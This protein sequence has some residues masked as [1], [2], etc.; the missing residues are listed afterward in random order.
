MTAHARNTLWMPA[1]L[2]ALAF[3]SFPGCSDDDPAVPSDDNDDGGGYVAPDLDGTYVIVDTDQSVCYDSQDEI[4]APAVGDA[5]YGQDAQIDGA[6]P[7]YV[8]STDSLTVYDEVTGLTWVRSADTDGDGQLES[9]VDKLTWVDAQTYPAEL[10][11]AAFGGFD[12]WRLP[13]I[14]ELYSLI[15]FSGEDVSPEAPS[16]GVPFIDTDI[17]SFVYGNTSAGERII[18]SQY[19]SS[20]L[21]VA[22]SIE[23]QLLFGVNFAD[24]RIKGYGL[25]MPGMG[26]KTFFVQCVRGNTDY[27]INVFTDNGDGTVS[28]D[29]TGL[30]WAQD[31]SGVDVSAGLNWEEALAWVKTQNAAGFL[32][33]GDWRL[34]NVK[35]LQS[36]V[37]YTRSPATTGSAAIDPVFHATSIINEA[38]EADYAFYW[39]ST[40]H[41]SAMG[42]GSGAYVAFGRSLGYMDGSWG[43]VHGA[44]SQRSDPKSGDPADFPT[45]NG[46]Q[47]DAIRIYNHVRLVR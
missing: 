14:K 20:T 21:Y 33:Y 4:A 10:N 8:V 43:D 32:G 31:D 5:F 28:D 44:G 6:Q 46:P 1:L 41:A 45:G 25:V 23:G 39:S 36:I 26:D 17:F 2:L 22:D 3:G 15:R 40:T 18:D 13:T 24:G 16:G 47:G 9:P 12:D 19:A 35:E 34:P 38:G 27:G 37:D 11:A 30:M 42:G 29:A 7:S